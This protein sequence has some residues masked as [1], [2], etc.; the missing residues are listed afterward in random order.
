MEK[1]NAIVKCM[2]TMSSW[3]CVEQLPFDIDQVQMLQDTKHE[4]SVI[5]SLGNG[6]FVQMHTSLLPS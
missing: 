1:F 3:Q 2:N 5:M 4:E 6:F